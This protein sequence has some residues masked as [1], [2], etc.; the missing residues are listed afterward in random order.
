MIFRF[1]QCWMTCSNSRVIS[2]FNK[3]LNACR[4]GEIPVVHNNKEVCGCAIRFLVAVS[5]K[6][7]IY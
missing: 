2:W 3:V 1:L 7:I 4:E 5:G 6:T